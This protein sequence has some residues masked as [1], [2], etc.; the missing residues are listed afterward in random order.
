MNSNAI[1]RYGICPVSVPISKSSTIERDSI[2]HYWVAFA[3]HEKP[4]LSCFHGVSP[5]KNNPGRP[6]FLKCHRDIA[7][8]DT[9]SS[10][11]NF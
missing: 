1:D 11:G 8:R 7:S 6:K 9:D 4:V 5:V 3:G 10:P 2:S